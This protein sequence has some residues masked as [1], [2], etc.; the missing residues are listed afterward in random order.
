[1]L[2]WPNYRVEKRR[3]GVGF[4]ERMETTAIFATLKTLLFVVRRTGYTPVICHR[5]QGVGLDKGAASQG[6]EK[7]RVVHLVDP[8]GKC[9]YSALLSRGSPARL[10]PSLQGFAAGRRREAAVLAQ[11]VLGHELR[12]LGVWHINM[13]QDVSNAFVCMQWDYLRRASDIRL[14][15]GDR[16]LGRQRV[17]WIVVTLLGSDGERCATPTVG[18]PMGDP[19]VMNCFARAFVVVVAEWQLEQTRWGEA[20]DFC[21]MCS[22]AMGRLVDAPLTGYVDDIFKK[23]VLGFMS[24]EHAAEK[25]TESN[26][27]LQ[28]ELDKAGYHQNETK[29]EALP[30]FV[31]VGSVKETQRIQEGEAL[32]KGRVADSARY[33]GSIYPTKV[34]T[35]RRFGRRCAARGPRSWRWL[36]CGLR[37][38]CHGGFAGWSSSGGWSTPPFRAWSRTC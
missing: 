11:Q 19:F 5:T 33:I 38:E 9:F 35:A 1:M 30:C 23:M 8:M 24:A 7:K 6:A 34:G 37:V 28:E 26:G 15:E 27:K 4:E 14:V 36:P 18:C 32:F 29:Q 3:Q 17:E 16:H 21:Y 25:A 20:Y 2:M 22:P 12:E 31:G 13:L 10:P